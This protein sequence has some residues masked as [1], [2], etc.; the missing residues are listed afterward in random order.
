MAIV[1]GLILS[2][3]KKNVYIYIGTI[4]MM[5]YHKINKTNKYNFF[6]KNELN[7]PHF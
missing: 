6:G 7:L 3:K 2:I 5:K 1:A 4:I